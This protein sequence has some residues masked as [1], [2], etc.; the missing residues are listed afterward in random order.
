MTTIQQL[1][2]NGM[3]RTLPELLEFEGLAI[4]VGA[5]GKYVAEGAQPLGLPDWSFPEQMLPYHAESVSTI[6]CYH[7]LEHLT[8]SDAILFLR[9]CER[10][11]IPGKSVLN[12]CIP[13]QGTMLHGHD[14]THKSTWNEE[15]FDSLFFK[16]RENYYDP[17]GEWL[18]RPH[19]VMIA[20]IVNRN[21][22][23]IGQLVRIEGHLATVDIR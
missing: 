8:G 16:T 23:L 11:M 17:A 18:L 2:L 6:H 9:E 12:F 5:T 4:D 14:L 1:F 22:A 21:I 3:K 10:V 13:Y 20:G 19:F 7:F 15:T